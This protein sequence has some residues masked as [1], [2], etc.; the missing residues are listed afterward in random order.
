MTKKRIAELVAEVKQLKRQSLVAE[1][2][3]FESL[4]G[5]KKSTLTK[6]N[7]A[8]TF[9][10][11]VSGIA[12]EFNNILGAVDGHAEWALDSKKTEDMVEALKVARLACRRSSD[13]THSLQGFFQPREEKKKIV[14]VK[15]LIKE[16]VTLFGPRAT[17]N[18]IQLKVST[19]DVEVFVSPRDIVEIISNLLNNALDSLVA[20]PTKNPV[21]EIAAK[22]GAKS[23][24]IIVSDNGVGVPQQYCEKVFMPF[25]TTK[26][27]MKNIH[28][29]N[30][31]L[32][33]AGESSR[34]TAMSG[35]TG[36]GLF[37]SRS[38][39]EQHGGS[40]ELMKSKKSKGASFEL[41][42]PLANK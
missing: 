11:F 42:L 39:A 15:N 1:R 16:A 2:L 22:K 5:K 31:Q 20:H 10:I 18:K 41:R 14:S 29:E 34:Q 21:I 37:L 7:N 23:V 30:P 17:T 3:R 33:K 28:R 35:G 40:L 25:F 27:V 12:H 24:C 19:V 13:I 4:K 36:L 6:K 26:G 32:N 38:I 9:E 8:E